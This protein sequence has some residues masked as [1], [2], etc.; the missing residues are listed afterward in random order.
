MA[1]L[2]TEL[3]AS[4]GE[5]SLSSEPQNHNQPRQ[6]DEQNTTSPVREAGWSRD[7]KQK[8]GRHEDDDE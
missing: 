1:A 4:H 3:E 6:I 7:N 2:V 5:R 8:E